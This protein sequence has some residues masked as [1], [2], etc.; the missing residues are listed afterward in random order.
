MVPKKAAGKLGRFLAPM[1]ATKIYRQS[2]AASPM[3]KM[4]NQGKAAKAESKGKA[5]AR[6]KVRRPESAT[7]SSLSPNDG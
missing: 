5:K 1:G 4:Q 3:P 2:E 7:C 6:S